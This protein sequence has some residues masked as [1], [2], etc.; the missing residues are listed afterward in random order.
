MDAAIYHDIGRTNADID[1]NHG[2]VS[3]KIYKKE[4]GCNAIVKFLI[5]Q[6]CIDD[7]ISLASISQF[8]AQAS[9][10]LLLYNILKDADALDRV[11]FGR[12]L[13][14]LNIDLLRLPE[15]HDLVAVANALLEY[16]Y[17]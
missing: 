12:S 3:Y 13:D 17:D 2:K 9:D 7:S 1:N 8:S 10:V 4:K 15:S 6:H 16:K 11:R 5:E 14:G